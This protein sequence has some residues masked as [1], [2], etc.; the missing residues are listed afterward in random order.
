MELTRETLERRGKGLGTKHAVTHKRTEKSDR[1]LFW[2]LGDSQRATMSRSASLQT[3]PMELIERT[4]IYSAYTATL[5]DNQNS[6]GMLKWLVGMDFYIR[7]EGGSRKEII[8]IIEKTDPVAY[9]FPDAPR[10]AVLW[11][12]IDC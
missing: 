3:L 1:S 9:S 6:V 5:N 12:V 11:T 7:K 4:V 2:F 10:A 8:I